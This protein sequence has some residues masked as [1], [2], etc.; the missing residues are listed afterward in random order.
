MSAAME[1]IEFLIKQGESPTAVLARTGRRPDSIA[2]LLHR[3]G[4]TDLAREYWRIAV[5]QRRREAQS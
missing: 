5:A 2:R 4:R 1:D 3:N